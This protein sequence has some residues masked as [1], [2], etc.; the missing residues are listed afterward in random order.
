MNMHTRS[1]DVQNNKQPMN[2]TSQN[3]SYSG[4]R[5]LN[6]SRLNYNLLNHLTRHLMK[7]SVRDTIFERI[8]SFPVKKCVFQ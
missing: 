4:C 3:K 1:Q 2:M 5:I 8:I 7:L 6:Y